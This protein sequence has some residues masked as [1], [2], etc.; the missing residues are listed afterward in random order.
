MDG[1]S[2]DARSGL[3]S[4]FLYADDLILK[5]PTMEQ[6]DRRVAEWGASL[7]DKGLKV[8]PGKSRVMVG[9]SGGEMIVN[10]PCG[11]VVSVGKE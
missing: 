7:M 6:P 8:N 1:V 3:P 2:S 11:P 5:A 4:E 9:S 10:W